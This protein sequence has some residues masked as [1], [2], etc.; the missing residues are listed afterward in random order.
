MNE[1]YV[2][3][4]EWLRHPK[5][6]EGVKARKADRTAVIEWTKTYQGETVPDF[7]IAASPYLIEQGKVTKAEPK[8]KVKTK[9][10]DK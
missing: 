5:D 8:A 6:E 7:V 10:A 3:A 9:A 1:T 2:C 4:V